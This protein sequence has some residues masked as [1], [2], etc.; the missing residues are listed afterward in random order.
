MNE[1]PCGKIKK[2]VVRQFV[3]IPSRHF[4]LVNHV[5]LKNKK[6]QRVLYFYENEPNRTPRKLKE[7]VKFCNV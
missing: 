5:K 3:K 1:K 6:K 4:V 2:I 7:W